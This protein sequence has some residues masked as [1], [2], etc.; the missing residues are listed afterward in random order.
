MEYEVIV[1]KCFVCFRNLSVIREISLSENPAFDSSDASF[2][3]LLSMLYNTDEQPNSNFKKLQQGSTTTKMSETPIYKE[4]VDCLPLILEV[5]QRYMDSCEILKQGFV[6]LGNFGVKNTCEKK[7]IGLGGIN[8]LLT[9]LKTRFLDRTNLSDSQIDSPSNSPIIP[10]SAPK[11]AQQF[12]DEFVSHE[13]DENSAT[14]TI[15]HNSPRKRIYSVNDILFLRKSLTALWNLLF[16]E[17]GKQKFFV[18]ANGISILKG[19]KN[20]IDFQRE[21]HS[22]L[23]ESYDAILAELSSYVELLLFRVIEWIQEVGLGIGTARGDDNNTKISE[24]E[25]KSDVNIENDKKTM[26]FF[27]IQTPSIEDFELEYMF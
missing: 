16:C 2:S 4:L 11:K 27:E 26:K 10:I 25:K 14:M 18:E 21:K 17:T 15:S 8:F 19:L 23:L 6:I 12:E 24:K 1:K 9:F 20:Q 13:T 7:I 22:L 3:R 5:M